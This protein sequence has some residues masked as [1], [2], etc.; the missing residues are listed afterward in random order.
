MPDQPIS[1]EDP[2]HAERGNT[3]SNLGESH[4]HSHASHEDI[5]GHRFHPAEVEPRNFFRRAPRGGRRT[6]GDTVA[7]M[8]ARRWLW[9]L[10]VGA[11]FLLWAIVWLPGRVISSEGMTPAEYA[12]AQSDFRTS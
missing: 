12:S 7:W 2:S 1:D 8:V 4:S 5:H 10:I 6:L 9:A 11:A 3:N